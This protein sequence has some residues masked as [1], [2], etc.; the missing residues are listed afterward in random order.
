MKARIG[1]IVYWLFTALA[2]LLLA[3]SPSN[4]GSGPNIGQVLAGVAFYAIGRDVRRVL[5][6]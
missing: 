4:N 1:G 6:E 3:T 5:R 2:V